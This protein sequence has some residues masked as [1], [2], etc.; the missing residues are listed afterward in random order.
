M[1]NDM[2][3]GLHPLLNCR[4]MQKKLGKLDKQLKTVF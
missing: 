1:Q 3:D 4:N 2:E